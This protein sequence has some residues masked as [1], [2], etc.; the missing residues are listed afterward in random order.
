MEQV[1][2]RPFIVIG[3]SICG[4]PIIK[5]EGIPMLIRS[6]VFSR[7]LSAI[8]IAGAM[9]SVASAQEADPVKPKQDMFLVG[10]QATFILQYLPAFHSPY[11]G[12]NSLASIPQG[13]LSDTYTVYL[14]A[15]VT[16]GLDFYLNP[17]MARG[18]GIG[19]A[20]G[21]AGY[22]N[23][24]V[25]RN[26]TLGQD[27]YLARYYARWTIATGSGEQQADRGENQISEPVPTHRLVITGGK[28]GTN[29]IFDLN[30]Y[31]NSTRTE[32]MN[33]ALLNDA[34]YDYAADTRGYTQ[35]VA[36][37][38]VQP[39]YALRVGSFLM[40][41]VAN[42]IGLDPKISNSRGD[43]AE[44]E[45]HPKL[46]SGK[47]P[48]VVRL[49]GYRN[50]ADMG[51]YRESLALAAKNGGVPDIAATRE[52]GRA[53]YGLGLNMEQPLGDGGDTG[54]FARLGWS[55][56]RTESFAYTEADDHI[57]LGAQISGKRWNLPTDRLGV[58]LVSDGLSAPHRD[59]LAAGG[60]GFILGDGRL[61]YGRENI[62]ETYYQRQLNKYASIA[63]DFQLIGNPGY[64]KDRGPISVVSLR[65]H[66]EY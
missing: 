12:V 36:A 42:G 31:A 23:G 22:T 13:R 57:S 2:K 65:L 18:G 24:D 8:F 27:P 66:F 48:A 4:A 35:G 59:Y 17:E 38:W 19:N 7:R 16:N 58:A 46:V 3:A 6:I 47:S 10:G 9:I 32:F 49:L 52:Q 55:D 11:V 40:P 5:K 15:H 29:D 50:L 60:S 43:Q 51:D 44:L 37:E 34:A 56:G 33:W 63:L 62:F 25:I 45:I 21:L 30:A 39:G 26:P 61:N 20:L 64:N 28:L 53:K 54:V 14:G 41:K 1:S